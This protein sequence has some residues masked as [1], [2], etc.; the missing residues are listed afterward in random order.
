MWTCTPTRRCAW[1]SLS[2]RRARASASMT[3]GGDLGDFFPAQSGG[4]ALRGRRVE[5][6]VGGL[7]AL[8]PGSEVGG[9]LGPAGGVL[10]G[11]GP[12]AHG[13]TPRL[14]RLL[15]GVTPPGHR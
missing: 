6:D 13:D 1:A 9:E 2:R 10:V 3:D 15:P 5:P 11:R 8:A 12:H 14:V 7:E 4:V